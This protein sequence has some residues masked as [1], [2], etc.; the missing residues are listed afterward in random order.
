MYWDEQYK[1][2]ARLWGETPSV[3]ALAAVKYLQEH[4]PPAEVPGIL[5]IGC[6]YGR[7]AFYLSEHLKCTVFGIDIAEKAIEMAKKY[8]RQAPRVKFRCCGFTELAEGGFDI[9]FLSNFY[10]LLKKEERA[11]LR[12]TIRNVLKPNGLLFL[13]TLSNR[14]P[15]HFGKGIPVPNEKNSFIENVYLH[16]CERSELEKD[17]AFLTIKELDEHEYFEPRATGE[18]H[19]H[20]SWI[21]IG[22]KG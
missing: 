17:F 9:V 22:K 19:R 12:R 14:D 20:I 13:S 5:D 16:F 6:G 8:C 7:D 21:L 2:N 4:K 11:E 10:Q 1:N 18:T 3:L 15:E